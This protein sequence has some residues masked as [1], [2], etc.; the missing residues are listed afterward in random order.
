MT[1]PS[2]SC[3][4]CAAPRTGG[5]LFAGA[6]ASTNVA[7]R[8]DEYFD[9]YDEQFW[10]RTLGIRRDPY[11]RLRRM[12]KLAQVISCYRANRGLSHS[13][14]SRVGQ[15][16]IAGRKLPFDCAVIDRYLR[17]VSDFNM[18]SK[19]DTQKGLAAPR[20]ARTSIPPNRLR[21]IKPRRHLKNSW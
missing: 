4:I 17:A 9:T 20:H 10:I 1:E 3:V 18:A 8:P 21:N 7:G 5:S 16:E 12:N 2:L 6:I 19:F 14:D 15:C 11:L 13:V